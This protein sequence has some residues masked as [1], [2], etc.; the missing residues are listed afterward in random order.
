MIVGAGSAGCVLANRLSEDRDV[1]VLV[2]EAGP[3]D[4]G[5]GIHMPLAFSWPLANDR[6]NWYYESDPEPYLD[7]RRMYCPRGRVI[8]VPLGTIEDARPW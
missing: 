7:G 1:S 5:I 4:R 6:F 3:A 2:L 8:G